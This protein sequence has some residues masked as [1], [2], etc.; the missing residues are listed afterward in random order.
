MISRRLFKL[1]ALAAV[2][3]SAAAIYF[4]WVDADAGPS[5]LRQAAIACG[6]AA[7][8]TALIG[9][10][11]RPR[12]VL[13]F[14]AALLAL[15]S[16]IAIAADWSAPALNGMQPAAKS[17]L[18]HLNTFTPAL[19]SAMRAAVIRAIGDAAW[20]PVLTSVLN[21]PS[22]LLF[23]ILALLAGFAGRPRRQVRI[24]IN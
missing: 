3:A 10:D 23:A 15:I 12:I 11:T 1:F 21:L 8:V 16:V 4:W 19:V 20:D 13:R 22:S 5:W 24:F 2:V 7:L 9:V 6:L 17:L 18:D 14:L